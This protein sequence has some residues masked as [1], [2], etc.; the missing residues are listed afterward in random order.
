MSEFGKPRHCNRG[1]GALVYFD[2][3]SSVGHPAA[4]KWIPLEYKNGMKT[5]AVHECPNKGRN[6]LSSL[7]GTAA[8]VTTAVTP[9]TNRDVIKAIR[10]ALDEYIAIHE[11]K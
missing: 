4:D 10:T 2:A 6:G 1:C 7:T 5:D 11:G 8:A 9:V 3:H